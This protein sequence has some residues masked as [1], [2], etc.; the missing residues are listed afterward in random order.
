[1]APMAIASLRGAQGRLPFFIF[2]LLSK[3]GWRAK[4]DGVVKIV[5]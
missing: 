2:P 4:P 1:M 5:R 3:E